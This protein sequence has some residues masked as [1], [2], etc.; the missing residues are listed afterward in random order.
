MNNTSTNRTIER[1]NTDSSRLL[2]QLTN[3]INELDSDS[4][5]DLDNNN[6]RRIFYS[7]TDLSGNNL[8]N[9]NTL[10]TINYLWN[11]YRNI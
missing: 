2:Q 3:I 8:L 6:I 9:N 10:N 7:I 1:N 4:N 5:F 11:T